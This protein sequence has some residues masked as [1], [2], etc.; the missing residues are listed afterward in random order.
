MMHLEVDKNHYS[1]IPM[2]YLT[3]SN[4]RPNIALQTDKGWDPD[5]VVTPHVRHPGVC[6]FTSLPHV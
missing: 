2:I 1:K 5:V 6:A 4:Y 3:T